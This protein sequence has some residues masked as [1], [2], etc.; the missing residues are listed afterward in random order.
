MSL[1]GR[2]FF[3]V[4]Q[5]KWL[6][7]SRFTLP[8]PPYDNPEYWDRLYKNMDATTVN[9]W[10]NFDVKN[11]LRHFRYET[12]LHHGA[13]GKGRP[14][15]QEEGL[16]T[17]T[18]AECMDICQLDTPENA[19][20]RYN[21]HKTND[22]DE[23]VLLLGC[24]NSKMG[25]Q[26]LQDSFVGPV[27][28]V[29]ISSKAIQLMTQRYQKYL[30]GAAVKRMEFIVD[31]ARGLTALS[32][33]SVGGGVLDKGLIDDLHCADPGAGLLDDDD[34]LVGGSDKARGESGIRRIVDS[35]H[36][37]LRPARP[38]VFFSRSGHEYML[39]RT[40]GSVQ[41]TADIRKKWKDVQV[42]KLVDL[43]V[44]L[45]RFVKAD[46]AGSGPQINPRRRKKRRK[47]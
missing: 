24:G 22:S 40:L 15:P 8:S 39:R 20:D 26:I 45:Y 35:V 36:K 5:H 41:W 31:D 17:S 12:V 29:D 37:V 4:L 13:K 43:E 44:I 10:G 11:G 21:E 16:H 27:L 32:P 19:I 14:Q 33:E 7:S 9:E 46:A 38:F 6:N 2:N 42:L 34:A 18:F 25:E 23:S 30:D 3:D 1:R 28:Q 47:P